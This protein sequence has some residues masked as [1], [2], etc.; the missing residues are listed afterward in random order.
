MDALQRV[1]RRSRPSPVASM[2]NRTPSQGSTGSLT[3]PQP[4]TSQLLPLRQRDAEAT[5]W[6]R[7]PFANMS[8]ADE[9]FATHS[10]VSPRAGGPLHC[11]DDAQV[12]PREAELGR[13]V[14]ASVAHRTT[15]STR[16][17][18]RGRGR[19]DDCIHVSRRVRRR[20]IVQR[21]SVRGRAPEPVLWYAGAVAAGL[22]VDRLR[23][24]VA[25][26]APE[27]VDDLELLDQMCWR[28]V[29]ADGDFA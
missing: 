9:S 7:L 28:S 8:P 29:T 14:I 5:P 23:V 20:G 3:G 16:L 22:R 21:R 27:E 2:T 19:R 24:R 12:E 6:P 17:Q 1:H 15:G 13:R 18:S 25:R 11:P 4:T 10:A 26:A